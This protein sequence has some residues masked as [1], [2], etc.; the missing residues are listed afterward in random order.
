MLLQII[1]LAQV[2]RPLLAALPVCTL[3]VYLVQKVY[4]RTSR[5]LRVLELESHSSLNSWFLET[6]CC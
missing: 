1:L 3:V 5:Q 6:V 4:L 2:Q